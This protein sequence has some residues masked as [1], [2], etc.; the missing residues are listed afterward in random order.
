MTF[1][2]ELSIV[3]QGNFDSSPS[4]PVIFGV[5]LTPKIGGILFG[6]LGLAGSAYLF[7]NMVMPTWDTYSL[8]QTKK[9]DLQNQINQKKASVNQ[10]GKVKEELANSK[11]QQTQVLGLFANEKTLDTLLIDLNRL[12][13]AGNGQLPVAAVKGKL[14]KYTPANQKA[15]PVVDGSLGAGAN[16]KLKRSVISVEVVGTYEQTQS[17]L[18]NV[19][20]LQPLLLVKEYSSTLSADANN[21]PEKGVP[22]RIGPAPINTSF[23]LQALVPLSPEELAAAQAAQAAAAA[24]PAK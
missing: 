4:Y 2:D 21:P 5:T 9:D 8:N 14:K 12:V 18:R 10:I 15:E 20:R 3:D 16:G 23:Q 19:E 17:I 24:T 22:A 1:S 13:E 6:V 11:V 7:L